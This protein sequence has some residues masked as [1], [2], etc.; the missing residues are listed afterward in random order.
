VIGSKGIGRLG[1]VEHHG[2]YA[3]FMRMLDPIYTDGIAFSA[4]N[5]WPISVGGQGTAMK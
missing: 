4:G 2:V 3:V 5:H 1:R